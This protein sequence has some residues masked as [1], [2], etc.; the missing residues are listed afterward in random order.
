VLLTDGVDTSSKGV[1]SDSTIR[2]A[3]ASYVSI[4]PVQYHTYGDFADSPSR[5]TYAAWEFGRTAHV[6]KSGEPASAAYKRATLFLRLLADKTSGHF[7]FADRTKNLA[8]SFEGIA[9]Q[10]RQQYTLGYYPKNR[11]A[12]NTPRKVKVEVA[13]PKASVET[14][15]SY[16]YKPTK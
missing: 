2:A 9:A 1:T 15:K 14:R 13:V 4:Y 6:T 7:Q 16:I 3:E 12:N 11:V 10:L 5:E 8:R